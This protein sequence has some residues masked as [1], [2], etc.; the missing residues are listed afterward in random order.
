MNTKNS[1]MA[2]LVI[3]I[4]LMKMIIMMTKIIIITTKTNKN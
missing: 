1:I 2:E 4:F 3:A